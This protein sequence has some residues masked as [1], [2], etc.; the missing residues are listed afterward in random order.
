VKKFTKK[1]VIYTV[2]KGDNINDIAD[3]F[4]V[5]VFE[6]KSWNKLKKNSVNYGRK[7]T[8]WIDGAKLGILP[9]NQ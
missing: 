8:I 7:L 3:W 6:I 5:S 2:K 9:E 1:K 4:D